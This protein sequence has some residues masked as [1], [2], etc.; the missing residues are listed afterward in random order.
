M[1]KTLAGFV[2]GLALALSGAAVAG[3]VNDGPADV[4][5]HSW[6]DPGTIQCNLEFPDV[7]H[8]RLRLYEDGDY[9]LG[10]DYRPGWVERARVVEAK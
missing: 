9:S 4:R 2:A 1:I 6:N 5:C 10:V 3:T 8:I 7:D